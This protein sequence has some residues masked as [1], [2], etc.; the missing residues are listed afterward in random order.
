ML[1]SMEYVIID[2][3]KTKTDSERKWER[4]RE[5]QSLVP[6]VFH[7]YL[8]TQENNLNH[9]L[10]SQKTLDG[11]K[12]EINIQYPLPIYIPETFEI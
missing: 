10:R 6:V 3:K 11:I 1:E 7:F 2:V 12:P 8:V 9:V 5:N 4:E